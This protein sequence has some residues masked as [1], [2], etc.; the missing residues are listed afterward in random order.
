[1]WKEINPIALICLCLK[2]TTGLDQAKSQDVLLHMLSN[3]YI[4]L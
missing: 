4:S 3:I 2:G 1:M